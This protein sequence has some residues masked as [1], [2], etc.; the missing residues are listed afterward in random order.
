MNMMTVDVEDWYH[1]LDGNLGHWDRYEDR[2]DVSLR[3]LLDVFRRTQSTA[4]FFV[5]GHVAERHLDLVGEIR[6][7]GHEVAS[8]GSP[9]FHLP[10]ASRAV[11]GR[12]RAFSRSPQR[13]RGEAGSR[14][15]G[16]VFLDH[17][18]LALGLAHSARTGDPL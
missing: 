16:A 2:I 11:Q 18:V 5:L 1:C 8:H 15:S 14:L 13:A 6:E 3:R 12:R 9:P 17:E 7:G 4:T 10:S